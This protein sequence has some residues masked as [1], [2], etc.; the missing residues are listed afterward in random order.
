MPSSPKP[1][2]EPD[3]DNKTE[4]PPLHRQFW[5]LAESIAGFVADGM[6]TVSKLQYEERLKICN[7]CP[8]R[9][10]NRCLK[11]GC[12]LSLK[13]RGRAMKCPLN[14]WPDLKSKS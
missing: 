2:E 11:C 5:N 10:D 4:L 9:S 6:Q 3:H 8:Q 1:P 13:A 14:K 7:D 12:N